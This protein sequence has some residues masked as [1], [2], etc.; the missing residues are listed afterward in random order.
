MGQRPPQGSFDDPAVSLP[1]SAAIAP[2]L[3]G[4]SGDAALAQV[5]ADPR[6]AVALPYAA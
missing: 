1:A 6:V 3:R 5:A 2:D 4:A